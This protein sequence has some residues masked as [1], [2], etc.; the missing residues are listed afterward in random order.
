MSYTG[1][2]VDNYG[3]DA[4]LSVEED[5]TAIDISGYST[6]QMILKDPDG[7]ETTKTASFINDGADGLLTYTIQS[8][9]IDKIGT[10]QVRA[11]LDSELK[12]A[13]H[14]FTVGA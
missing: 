6:L 5:S 2:I 7:I 12:T 1:I 9:D 13:W 3:W 11:Y 4:E 10:W 14:S 8:G